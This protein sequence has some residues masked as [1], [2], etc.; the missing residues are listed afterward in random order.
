MSFLVLSYPSIR[1]ADFNWIQ[2]YR[3]KNDELYFNI[4]DPHFT[5]VFPVSDRQEEE[6][7][8][9]I[10]MQARGIKKI[11]FE[12]NRAIVEKDTF[13]GYFHEFL[14]PGKGYE[15][16]VNFHN[17]LYSKGLYSNL[18]QDLDYIPHIGIGNSKDIEKC[19]KAIS[20]L[21]KVNLSIVGR[22]EKLTIVQ[23]ENNVI[24]KKKEIRL[25]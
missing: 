17:R 3:K 9:E 7:T 1:Q 24:Y 21:N 8:R 18:R 10:E 13:S 16:I 6:F 20:N 11:D 22:I 5:L 14:V 23:F 12:I 2:T 19:N 25:S 4:V 15:D